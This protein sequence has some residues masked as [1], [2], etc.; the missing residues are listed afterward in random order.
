MIMK[1]KDCSKD[2][3]IFH[4]LMNKKSKKEK[5]QKVHKIILTVTN[6]YRKSIPSI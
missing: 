2:K 5:C 1:M 3:N 6:N 4:R